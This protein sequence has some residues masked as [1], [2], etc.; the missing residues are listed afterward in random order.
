MVEG[1]LNMIPIVHDELCPEASPGRPICYC[2]LHKFSELIEENSMLREEVKRL[3]EKRGDEPCRRK[4]RK[5]K[6]R[7]KRNRDE[8]VLNKSVWAGQTPVQAG[9]NI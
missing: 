1:L 4:E 8:R 7:E 5:R 3:N 9:E 6:R 2:A